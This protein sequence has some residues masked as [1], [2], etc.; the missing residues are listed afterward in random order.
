VVSP[1]QDE[2]IFAIVALGT[3]VVSPPGMVRLP[4]LDPDRRYRV[5][6]LAPGDI[7]G[8]R[9]S[10]GDLAWWSAGVT[11]TGAVLGSVGLQAPVLNPEQMVLVHL[12]EIGAA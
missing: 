4:G 10:H 11:L 7:L 6:P 3:S 9:T 5:T 12:A 2:A 8:G 1:E